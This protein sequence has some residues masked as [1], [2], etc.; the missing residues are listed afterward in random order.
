MAV[1]KNDI[2]LRLFFALRLCIVPFNY[3]NYAAW[4]MQLHY[5]EYYN[6]INYSQAPT[7]DDIVWSSFCVIFVKLGW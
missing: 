2:G 4:N 1:N 5:A 3:S 6:S 7:Y